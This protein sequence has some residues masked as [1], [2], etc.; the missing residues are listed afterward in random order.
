MSGYDAPRP[1]RLAHAI[2]SR[3]AR[4]M[5]TPELVDDA[6]ELF[7]ERV[8][9]DGER[10]ARRWY[11]SQALAAVRSSLRL[12]VRPPRR[13]R[14][15]ATGGLLLDAKLGARMLVRY[16]GL[17]VVGGLAMA[18][19]I[20]VGAGLY[21]YVDG[22]MPDDDLPLPQGERVVGI[23][24][25]DLAEGER[26]LPRV[27]DLTMWRREL[28][29]IELLGGFRSVDAILTRGDETGAP[30]NGAEISPVGFRL[31]ATPPL[32]GRT[33][34]EAD[35]AA[36]AQPVVVL[37][38]SV[39][40]AR[41][42]ADPDVVG[43]VVRVDGE[44]TTVV[45]VMP[46]GFRFPESHGFWT[47]LRPGD[48]AADTEGVRVFGRLAPG[49]TIAD[50][51]AE[52]G[53]LMAS[54]PRPDGVGRSEGA[55]ALQ[56]LPYRESLHSM[57]IGFMIRAIVYQVNALAV[58]F[59]GLVAA[60]VALLMF[61]RAATRE[62]EI[63]V[64][65]ALGAGRVRIVTQL[66]VEALVLSVLATAVG[67]AAVGPG[68][69]WIV[70]RTY[71]MGGGEPPFWFDTRVSLSTSLYA[72]GLALLA[73]VVA[74]VLPA[75]KV[76]GRGMQSRLREVGAGG[77]GIRF[78]GVWTAVVV[79]QVAA[80]VVFTAS[81]FVMVRQADRSGRVDTT[82][83]ADRYLAMRVEMAGGGE[84]AGEVS[85]RYG[86]RLTELARRLAQ[87]PSVAGVTVAGRLPLTTRPGARIEIEGEPAPAEAPGHAVAPVAVDLSFFDV[88]GATIEAGRAFDR[89][90]LADGGDAVVVERAFVDEVL[91]GRAAVGR[92]IRFVSPGAH[93][94]P[95]PWLRIV[96]VV[97]SLE[98]GGRASLG[99]EEAPEPLVYR[100]L[101][102]SRPGASQLR[103]A[104]YVPSGPEGLAERVH[105]IAAGV[106]PTLRLHDVVR[107]D[108]I[109]AADVAF[110][111][112]WADLL[113]GI[114]AVTLGLALAGMWAVLSF[115]VARRRREIGVRVALG[116]GARRVVAEIFRQPLGHVAL[117][118]GL[119]LAVVAA[120]GPFVTR[121]SPTLADTLLLT[122]WLVGLASV[123]ML[124]C[125]QPALR[126]LR[127]QPAEALS[128]EE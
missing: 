48:R 128:A 33:L 78:G 123:A 95:G 69:E 119:G 64:R 77:G 26:V 27:E 112:L 60:N 84:P 13:A 25:W 43:G 121:G 23:R 16:P 11:R 117:G 62:R 104:A 4:R 72:G 93:A 96:G 73:A 71:E 52:V 103:L 32:L 40:Q 31:A 110:W 19:A 118:A 114:S 20:F 47:A 75:L 28:T 101:D 59:L 99:F 63:L 8:R 83:P 41:F 68:L 100:P 45:G 97:G 17:T 107:L 79:T 35:E 80:T 92:R 46:E 5:E 125:L 74:G 51:R 49:V 126:A 105:A 127:V 70:R 36:G 6:A 91:S 58:L 111:R 86:E 10:A 122:L 120:A 109:V 113:L 82:F 87:E 65:S 124:A 24:W 30:V 1:P 98:R 61:A 115:T 88:F 56:V 54:D 116:A 76:T 57:Q 7:V 34:V 106:H 50:A 89:A 94:E 38:F 37:G 85:A 42:G 55:I 44:P 102:P 3:A 67:L 53:A 29:S 90:D 66:F 2:L 9:R 21:E 18:F 39:W 22:I 81:A 12:A 15:S 14:R 108:R